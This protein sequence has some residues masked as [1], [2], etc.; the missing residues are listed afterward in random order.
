MRLIILDLETFSTGELDLSAFRSLGELTVYNSAD[1]EETV[2]RCQNADAVF[3]NR[4]PITED[5]ISRCPSVKFIGTF[6]T[7][8]NQVDVEACKKRGIALCNASDYSTHAVSQHAIA[9]ML[10]LAEKAQ[11]YD[12]YVRSGDWTKV[13]ASVFRFGMQE[14]YGKTFGIFGFGNIGRATAK[15]ADALGMNVIVHNRSQKQ[16]PYP[17]VSKEELFSRSDFLSLHAPLTAET[18]NF[19]NETTLSLMKISAYIINTARGGLIDESALARA[20]NEGKIAGAGLDATVHEP[21][22]ATDEILKAKNCIITP[23]I[24]WSPV[25]T[26]Q[27]LVKI[28]ANNFKEYLM[29]NS[30]NR[31][32]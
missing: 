17:Y 11:A 26:R 14:V 28:V 4:Y 24:G 8:F 9:L 32:C 22:L 31:I 18:H 10:M 21:V 1:E 20:L 6:S 30:V 29:G 27:R 13:D 12:C 3:T 19:V 15:V 16:S 25:E 23:H 5:L 7:G 2:R